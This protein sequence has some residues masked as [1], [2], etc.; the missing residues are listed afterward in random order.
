MTRI[1]MVSANDAAPPVDY[2]AAL[3]T[4]TR[5][6]GAWVTG[7]DRR[8]RLDLCNAEGSIL[9]GWND[10]AVE[11]AAAEV[12]D[13]AKVRV[14][15]LLAELTPGAEAVAFESSLTSAMSAVLLAAKA[16]TGR[17]GAYFCDEAVSAS[18]AFDTL[19]RAADRR[20]GEMAAI[21]IRPLDAPAHF[22]KNARRLADRIG[23]VLVFEESRSAL[24]V[25]RGGAQALNGVIADAAVFGSSLANGRGL[26]AVTGRMELLG[27][28]SRQGAEPEPAAFR[29]AEVVLERVADFDLAPALQVLGAEISAEVA[30]RLA[31]TGAGDFIGVHGDPC[32]SVMAGDPLFEAALSDAL[33]QEGVLSFGAHVLS[34]AVGEREVTAL[35]AAYDRVLP[36]LVAH[37]RWAGRR[38]G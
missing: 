17:D 35:L 19:A 37:T 28:V 24:R 5:R 26:A 30:Q 8:S 10:P 32:W 29:A 1:G 20:G 31:A 38:A 34:A 13:D 33:A 22:L 3:G 4:A 25:H 16:V 15:G 23:A 18:G 14:A 36:R 7:E 21:I 6:S 27:A 9:L 11:A 2:A 12:E